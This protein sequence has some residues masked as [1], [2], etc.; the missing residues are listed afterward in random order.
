MGTNCGVVAFFSA[1][2]A[3][4]RI[5]DLIAEVV[6]VDVYRI[7]PAQPYTSAD[8]DWQNPR[9]RSSLENA[10]PA[11]RPPLAGPALDMTAYDTLFL[12]YPI[13]W[14]QAPKAALTFL[15]SHDFGGKT[16]VPFCTSGSSPVGASDTDLHTLTD[17]STTWTPGIRFPSGASAA[18]VGRWIDGLGLP[19]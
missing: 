13:W 19:A 15:E 2:G 5:A 1:T 6:G 14:G 17:G 7:T 10:D 8:L 18:S 12:G 3:T 11:S 9:S 16:V 4:E